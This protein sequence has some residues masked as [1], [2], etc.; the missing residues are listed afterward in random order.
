MIRSQG[1]SAPDGEDDRRAVRRSLQPLLEFAYAP[2][3]NTSDSRDALLIDSNLRVRLCI[4]RIHTSGWSIVGALVDRRPADNMIS[5][6]RHTGIVCLPACNALSIE[7]A[8]I[9]IEP[10][11]CI[12]LNWA[13]RVPSTLSRSGMVDTFRVAIGRY[14]SSSMSVVAGFVGSS[15]SEPLV[16]GAIRSSVLGRKRSHSRACYAFW[17]RL[18]EAAGVIVD[19][20]YSFVA[21]LV[22]GISFVQESDAD[23]ETLCSPRTGRA[24]SKELDLALRFYTFRLA[25]V[26]V[27]LSRGLMP[28]PRP[29]EPT[30]DVLRQSLIRCELMQN[31]TTNRPN[32]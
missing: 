1:T 19:D 6:P 16:I 18:Q 4:H 31:P 24:R 2:W 3:S 23:L 22:G 9:A 26:H 11:D 28:I 32:D 14:A 8:I 27:Q 29:R 12:F 25:K 7:K 13:S 20:P 10:S 30:L 5:P 21:L 17:Q 15:A